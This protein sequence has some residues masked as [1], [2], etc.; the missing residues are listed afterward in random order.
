MS[1]GKVLFIIF[2]VVNNE[3]TGEFVEILAVAYLP[4]S[5][6]FQCHYMSLVD[7]VVS[8]PGCG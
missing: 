6:F 7:F 8:P 3:L 4:N 5:F 1:I 2:G